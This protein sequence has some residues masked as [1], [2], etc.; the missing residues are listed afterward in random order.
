MENGLK[1]ALAYAVK[2]AE[3]HIVQC[4]GGTFTD[5]PLER[6]VNDVRATALKMQTLTGL[7]DYIKKM[8]IDTQRYD[9]WI[10][11]VDSPVSVSAAGVGGS[12]PD[13]PAAA[14]R[15]KAGSTCRFS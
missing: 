15:A 12:R 4:D 10:V 3:P 14:V 1:E 7:V 5:K 2:L 11:Q 8:Q 6:V 9:R 13:P